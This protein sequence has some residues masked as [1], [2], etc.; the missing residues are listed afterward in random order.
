MFSVHTVVQLIK[1]YGI[2]DGY[3]ISLHIRI[4]EHLSLEGGYS[5]MVKFGHFLGG[6]GGGH[7]GLNFGQPKSEVFHFWEGGGSSGLK[8]Q[9]GVFWR[10]WTQIY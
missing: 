8:S 2:R 3:R 4:P 1:L 9:N 5:R 6:G 10:F 7:S